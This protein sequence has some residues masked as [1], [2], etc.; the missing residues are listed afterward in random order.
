MRIFILGNINSGKSYRVNQLSKIYN[1][2]IY[3]IDEYRKKYSDGT[4]ESEELCKK[5]FVDDVIRDENCIVEFSGGGSVAIDFFNKLP[6][7]SIVILH[8]KEELD[9][10][11]KRLQ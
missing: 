5:K 1:K 10:C 3:Q 9:I 4:I 2:N 6:L 7:K 8:V 11:I